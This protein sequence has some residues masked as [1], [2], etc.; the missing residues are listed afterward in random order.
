MQGAAYAV[1]GFRAP[2]VFGAILVVPV[3]AIAAGRG[4]GVDVDAEE[5][6][7]SAPGHVR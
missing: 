4:R 5:R 2:F 7:R 3:L 1:V 6:V